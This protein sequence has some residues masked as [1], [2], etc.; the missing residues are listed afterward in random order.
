MVSGQNMLPS[1]SQ[2]SNIHHDEIDHD[3]FI[4]SLR[5]PADDVEDGED[6]AQ[7][8]H[9]KPLRRPQQIAVKRTSEGG[10]NTLTNPRFK[11]DIIGMVRQMHSDM[12]REGLIQDRR[13][14]L[15]MYKS[16][17]LHKDG[18]RW[19]IDQVLK[20]ERDNPAS[21]S[22]SSHGR[23]SLGR[24][25]LGH[26]NFDDES[27]VCS[28]FTRMER[29][30][31]D[32]KQRAV[33][34]GN[35]M[36][37]AGY[38]SHV[39]DEHVFDLGK[40]NQTLFFRFHADTFQRQACI[41]SVQESTI[42]RSLQDTLPSFSA[43][44]RSMG[45]TVSNQSRGQGSTTS[46]SLERNQE[47][48]RTRLQDL[49]TTSN[50][51]ETSSRTSLDREPVRRRRSQVEASVH[52]RL[53]YNQASSSRS[54]LDPEGSRK[55]RLDDDAHSLNR[56][57][58]ASRSRLEPEAP[59]KSRSQIQED[60]RTKSIGTHIPTNRSTTKS[61]S[62]LE[63]SPVEFQSLNGSPSKSSSRSGSKFKETCSQ[64]EF[65]EEASFEM[66]EQNFL[67]F[68]YVVEN[69]APDSVSVMSALSSATSNSSSKGTLDINTN[70]EVD[71]ALLSMA[72]DFYT[73]FVALKKIKD[74]MYHLKVFKKC[75]L[76]D[77][78]MEWLARHVRIRH[79][80]SLDNSMPTLSWEE[81][82]EVAARLGNA[83]IRDGYISHVLKHCAFQPNVRTMVFFKF[84][85]KLIER[86]LHQLALRGICEEDIDRLQKEWIQ[87]EIEKTFVSGVVT[88]LEE[89]LLCDLPSGIQ[90]NALFQQPRMG[91]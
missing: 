54:R 3:L 45:K 64:E 39:C 51:Y 21:S 40:L 32:M 5:F 14:H 62:A 38:I 77:D 33:R 75:I 44:V 52:S 25:S 20:L 18:L 70:R 41:Q 35:L 80:D 83:M 57:L 78:A 15:K 8:R 91:F 23:H 86:D 72:R 26:Q 89:A 36:I 71:I 43:S 17:F 19:L 84:H 56:S 6:G 73:D 34:L 79:L 10:V 55:S 58:Y 42:R 68:C 65:F 9:Q 49:V 22:S 31:T 67:P 85:N 50:M 11:Y 1:R 16:C 13:W 90:N 88:G 63:R 74:R 82:E 76:H 4:K 30:V 87:K 48:I 27:S 66:D 7:M 59:P 2:R 60:N 81:A 12:I 69:N 53:Q 37:S 47:S 24:L 61:I 29:H 28:S 46:Q